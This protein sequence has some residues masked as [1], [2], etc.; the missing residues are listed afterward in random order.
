MLEQL[1]MRP[2]LVSFHVLVLLV[3]F[4]MR[5]IAFDWHEKCSFSILFAQI[6]HNTV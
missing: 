5:K 2:I 1:S 3:G 6:K 4:C